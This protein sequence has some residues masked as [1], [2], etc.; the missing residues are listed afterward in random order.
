MNLVDSSGWLAYF[1]GESNAKHFLYP[2]KDPSS[3]IVPTVTIYEVFKVVIREAHENAA[4]QAIAAMEKGMVVELSTPLAMAA[5]KISL[6]HGLPM[7]DSIILATARAHEAVIWTQDVD[8][9]D[10]PGVRYFPKKAPRH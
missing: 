9:K 1:S 5:S 10:L 4:L 7:A 2:L 8:F 3:L 6:E